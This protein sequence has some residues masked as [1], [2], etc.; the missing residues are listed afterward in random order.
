MFMEDNN[1]LISVIVPVYNVQKYVDRCIK[2]LINQTYQNIE[3]ILVDDGSTDKSSD[4][5]KR[6]NNKYPNIIYYRKK[7]GGLSSARNM[8]LSLAS[9][10][11]LMFVDSDDYVDNDY[12]I[13]AV[14]NQSQFN[15]DIVIFGYYRES[16]TTSTYLTLGNKSRRLSAGDASTDLINDSYAWNKLYRK[17]LFQDVHYPVGKTYEDGY[18]TYR[19]YDKARVISYCAHATYHYVETGQSIVSSKSADNIRDQYGAIVNIFNYLQEKHS[20]IAV[21]Y[22]YELIISSIR[23]VTYVPSDYDSQLYKIAYQTLKTSGIPQELDLTHKLSLVLFKISSP[24]A[25][26]IF[27]LRR[28]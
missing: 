17:E 28:N 14:E 15:A 5:C 16:T 25:I 20:K 6:Y 8:G 4:I 22:H 12:C 19:L 10:Q 21:K 7:N 3:I 11:F 23:Y 9:G 2:S 27:K 18:T 24:L 26:K 1:P 13:S